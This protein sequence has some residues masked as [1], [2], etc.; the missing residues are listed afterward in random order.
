V[1]D[2]QDFVHE[3]LW[4]VVRG[5][6]AGESGLFLQGL[7]LLE[8]AGRLRKYALGNKVCYAAA[9]AAAADGDA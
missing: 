1:V 8:K 2:L 4:L 9:G 3:A 7:Q 6:V 5:E